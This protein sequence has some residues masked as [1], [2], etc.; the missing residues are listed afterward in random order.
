MSSLSEDNVSPLQAPAVAR[1]PPD[2]VDE[3]LALD[4][5]DAFV[6][7]CFVV[8]AGDDDSTLV[9]D[10]PGVDA[11]VHEVHGAS[12]DPDA[13]VESVAPSR[14]VT[15]IVDETA[16][17]GTW[18]IE[19]APVANGSRVTVTE[20]GE[21]YNLIFRTLSRFVFGYTSTIDSFL[22]AA[23]TKLN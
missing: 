11:A 15:K 14:F 13:V 7:R 18:T 20:R 10:R 5:L 22:A 19:I 4:G 17:G 2:D 12:R 8:I 9:D 21:I 3:Q 1:H 16:F 23:R 6:Q